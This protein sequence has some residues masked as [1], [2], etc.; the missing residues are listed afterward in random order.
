MPHLCPLS[1]PSLSQQQ[2]RCLQD[3]GTGWGTPAA[4][5]KPEI[6][7]G[8]RQNQGLLTLGAV[9][10]EG[11]D[12][13][14]AGGVQDFWVSGGRDFPQWPAE[15]IVEIISKPLQTKQPWVLER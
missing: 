7:G 5:Q 2:A 6:V 1:I 10:H 4:L 3:T 15:K 8:K 11:C 12:V 13:M 14:G 9:H